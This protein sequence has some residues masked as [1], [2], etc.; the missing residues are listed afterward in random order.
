LGT[1]S[2]LQAAIAR[3]LRRSDLSDVIP[4]LIGLAESSMQRQL[5]TVFQRTEQV[6]NITGEFAAKPA[7]YKTSIAMRLTSGVCT[8]I[9]EW[10]PGEM[11]DAKAIPAVLSSYPRRFSSIGT[12]FEF[13]PVPDGPYTAEI[14]FD[15]GFTPLSDDNPTNWIL[16]DHSDAYLYGALSLGSAFAKNFE[17]AG[18]WKDEFTRVIGEIQ[19]ALRPSKSRKLRA[20]PALLRRGRAGAFNYLTGDA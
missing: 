4:D 8:P 12:Q 7:G 1:Y 16:A 10:S 20:D 2:D 3:W 15:T 13:Y 18:T 6:L 14:V 9:L 19:Y 11:S 17:N 5:E